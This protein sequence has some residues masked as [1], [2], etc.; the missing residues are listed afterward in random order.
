MIMEQFSVENQYRDFLNAIPVPV[1]EIDLAGK[2]IY[3]NPAFHYMLGYSDEELTGSSVFDLIPHAR[4]IETLKE[5]LSMLP[6][7]QPE[8]EPWRETNVTRTGQ[9]IDVTVYWNYKRNEEGDITGYLSMIFRDSSTNT[10]CDC[11][12][13]NIR[14]KSELVRELHDR[15]KNN[16]QIM[17]SI[18]SMKCEFVENEEAVNIIGQFQ[19]KIRNFAQIHELLY[20]QNSF[21][22]IEFD[23]VVRLIIYELSLNLP[24]ELQ[25]L[26]VKL[27]L[28][29]IT[30]SLREALPLALILSE[31]YN[32]T[33]QHAFPN[34]GEVS[35][36]VEISLYRKEENDT[37]KVVLLYRD[38]G[39]GMGENREIKFGYLLVESLIKQIEG[40]IHYLNRSEIAISF[41]K[42][43]NT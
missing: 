43:S 9:K 39:I 12:I 23:Q 10:D 28:D 38:N 31:L 20:Q 30:I 32:N 33:L 35:P 27:N 25:D 29:E 26:H 40:R 7:Q 42:P 24:P 34:P 5:Y 17:S 13:T 6:V 1:Q 21:I 16:M 4:E 14:E 11:T 2:I 37:A 15:V 22:N 8:P 3:A 19:E 18:M 36:Q 41:D